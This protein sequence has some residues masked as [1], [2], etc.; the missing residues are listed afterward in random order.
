MG[1]SKVIWSEKISFT[2]SERITTRSFTHQISNAQFSP[3]K[4]TTTPKSH[5]LYPINLTFFKQQ[6][7]RVNVSSK[8]ALCTGKDCC[9]LIYVKLFIT[10]ILSSLTSFSTSYFEWRNVFNK[11]M[12]LLLVPVYDPV[13][14]TCAL[15]IHSHLT[16]SNRWA[17]SF[18]FSQ[19]SRLLTFYMANKCPYLFASQTKDVLPWCPTC[20]SLFHIKF[21]CLRCFHL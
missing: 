4:E 19:V 12:H 8:Y 16:F 17:V 6:S 5:V 15:I 9:L 20:I 14:L 10:T 18:P 13:C 11:R 3:W 1:E 7:E 2:D 21:L